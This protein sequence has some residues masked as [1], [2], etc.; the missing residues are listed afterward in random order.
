MEGVEA[1]ADLLAFLNDEA[2]LAAV[3][4]VQRPRNVVHL[5]FD[6]R[7]L[8]FELD[9]LDVCAVGLLEVN[10]QRQ[11]VVTV[12]EREGKR[13]GEKDKNVCEHST[14]ILFKIINCYCPMIP[15]S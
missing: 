15:I 7:E 12:L 5:T 9:R 6:L 3:V 14:N 4:Q 2:E 11:L 13:E 10:G 8:L 1:G